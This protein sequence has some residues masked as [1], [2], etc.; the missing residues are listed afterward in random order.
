MKQQEISSKFK[1]AVDQIRRGLAVRVSSSQVI[2]EDVGVIVDD[3]LVALFT[4]SMDE[5]HLLVS[6]VDIDPDI[7]IWEDE[8][9]TAWV[10]TLDQNPDF[11]KEIEILTDHAI[12]HLKRLGLRSSTFYM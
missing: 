5:N 7:F 8:P 10:V 11:I 4:A 2:V 12:S 1:L 9:P 3:C 6:L